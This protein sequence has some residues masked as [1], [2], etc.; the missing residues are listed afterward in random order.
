MENFENIQQEENIDIKA[1]VFKFSRHWYLFVISIFVAII[2]AFLFNKYT[3]PEY[4]V[5][6][7][8]LVKDNKS[9]LD[10]SALLG[11]G[12]SNT[13]QNI[14]NEIG[15]LSS[16]TLAYRSVRKLHFEVSYFEK[17][18]LMT[19]EMYKTAPFEIVFD[20]TV[21]QAVGLKYDLKFLN[22]N[23]YS[24]EA[25]GEL[26][27]K[28]NYAKRKFEE[29]QIDK[30]SFKGK[31][32]FGQ[33]V[34]SPYNRFKI[35][36]NNKFD[37]KEDL[38]KGFQF[39]FNDYV[40]LTKRYMGVKIEPINREASILKLTLK[41]HT[42][43][44]AVDYLNMLTEQYLDRNLEVK[45]KIAENTINFIN[46]QL[47]IISDS[48]KAAELNLQKFRSKNEVMDISF[49]AQQVFQYMS[50]LEKQKAE[51]LIKSQYY[52]NLRNY[53]KKNESNLNNLVAPSAM[54]I[55]DP[56]LNALVAQLIELF[57][58]KAEALLYSTQKSPTIITI[59]SQI[60]ST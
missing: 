49:Q 45:N 35:I 31:F 52:N 15:K 27:Q 43:P 33:E 11:I 5:S 21:P 54:G 20:T 50:D 34:R 29:G 2:V 12:L 55:E 9:K 14:E 58:K 1:L 13:Q 25:E 60:Q 47:R 6:S 39:V 57:N 44:K 36:L 32:R 46:S 24:L 40:S 19:K 41:S 30:V 51:L 42:L 4:E 22:K 28:Y 23:E 56:A 37:P 26:I 53:I 8:V 18:G 38:D 59:N 48:L 10:P 3:N 16:F 17:E 7:T